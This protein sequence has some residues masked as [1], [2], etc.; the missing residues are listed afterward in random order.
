MPD[1]PFEVDRRL[2]GPGRRDEDHPGLFRRFGSPSSIVTMLMFGFW[3]ANSFFQ[4]TNMIEGALPSERYF[5]DRKS[6]SIVRYYAVKSRDE[7]F[8]VLQSQFSDLKAEIISERARTDS[9]IRVLRRTICRSDPGNC[10]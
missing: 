5:T 1:I 10:I 4:K 9:I 2:D 7:Q 6:D 8:I 3:I